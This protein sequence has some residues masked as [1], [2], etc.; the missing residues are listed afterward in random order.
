[1]FFDI[2]KL[3]FKQARN[4]AE[5]VKLRVAYGEKIMMSFVDIEPNTQLAEHSHPHE[6]MGMFLEGEAEFTIGDETK[7]VKPGMT[8]LIPPNVKHKVVTG[9]KPVLALDIFSPPREE[10][11]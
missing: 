6:Q 3:E 1:M 10:Y 7:L 8:Y 2:D 4:L 9:D 5:G 11:K